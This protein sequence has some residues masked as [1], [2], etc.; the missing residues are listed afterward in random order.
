[1]FNVKNPK[2]KNQEDYI[3]YLKEIFVFCWINERKY[4]FYW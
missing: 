2:Q 3:P 1:L 4:I